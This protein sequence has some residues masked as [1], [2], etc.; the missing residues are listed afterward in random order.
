M[1]KFSILTFAFFLV[2]AGCFLYAEKRNDTKVKP[3]S[4]EVQWNE[5]KQ[6]IAG[7]GIAQAG[8][9]KELFTFKN[10]E[11][12]MD[13]MFGQD[14][15]R[16]N[17]FR[18][19]VFPHYWE[20]KE[21]KSFDL[22][23]DIHL[24]LTDE[25]F[26]RNSDDLLRRGQLWATLQAKNKYHVDKLFFSTW[27]APAWMKDNG[28]VSQGKLKREHYQDFADYLVAFYKAYE[29]VG[30][31]S[32][33]LSPSNEPG[34]AAPWNSSLWSADEMG[35]FI[36]KYLGPTFEKE[37]I[38]ARIV[39][40]ENPYWSVVFPALTVVSSSDFTNTVLR[41]YP[42]IKRFNLIASGHGYDLK[43]DKLPIYISKE[44]LVTPIIPF[45]L[46]E[47]NNIPV[48]VTEISNTTPLDLSMPDGL[49][50]GAF[51][52]DYLTKANVNAI[53]WWAGAM[54]CENNESL[55]VLNKN[56]TDYE[57]A[58]RFYVF[59]NYTRYITEGSK[60]I[61]VKCNADSLLVS[62]YKKENGYVI[63]AVNPSDHEIE[64]Q[65]SINGAKSIGTLTRIITDETNHW[66][67]SKVTSTR[68]GQYMLTIPALSIATF[69]GT[70]KE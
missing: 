5:E 37:K 60:R 56:R 44:D 19:E 28:K 24:A 14:G 70:V 33:A 6:V 35:E 3:T 42:E 32:Y 55:I 4:I 51:F 18:G 11:E 67:E 48:W 17:I 12:V 36:A 39:F 68:A 46:A 31:K 15:L 27:S 66:T 34:Y 43:A 57:I 30:L 25:D 1:R 10:R 50:W 49:Q 65:L 22:E 69:V 45:E 63:V 16:L 7:F 38:P 40:G 20:S 21:D 41:N 62:A 53:V 64:T 58:K 9:A 13:K 54:P 52:H 29:S 23:D 61:I 59:G 26:T 47:Q 2:G 8:W